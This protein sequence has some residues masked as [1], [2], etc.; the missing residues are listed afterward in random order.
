MLDHDYHNRPYLKQI[1]HHPHF[2]TPL[3]KLHFINE[4]SDYIETVS[5]TDQK[6]L[7]LL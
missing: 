1:E 3:R 7:T 5:I 4:F 2:W 6:G